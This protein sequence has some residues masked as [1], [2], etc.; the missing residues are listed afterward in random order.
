ML[1]QQAR[2]ALLLVACVTCADAAASTLK[3]SSC[4]AFWPFVGVGADSQ[5]TGFDVQFWGLVYAEMKSVAQSASDATALAMLG[6]KAPDIQVTTKD[7]VLKGVQ[8]GSVDVGLCGFQIDPAQHASLDYSSPVVFSGYKAIVAADEPELTGIEVLKGAMKGFNESAVFSILMLLILS[9]VNAHL[10]WLLE[11][12]DNVQ[13]SKEY[14]WGVFDSWWLSVVTALTV[15]YGDKVPVT[16]FGRLIIVVWMFVGTYCVGMFGAAVTSDFLSV[17]DSGGTGP[18]LS[19]KSIADLDRA[20]TVGTADA[21]ARQYVA[22]A[23]PGIKVTQFSDTGTLLAALAEGMIQVAV[24]EQWHARWLIENDDRFKARNLIPVGDVFASKAHA[25]AISRPVQAVGARGANPIL[26]TLNQAVT[27]LVFGS[28]R[29]RFESVYNSWMLQY[30]PRITTS[31]RDALYKALYKWNII[32]GLGLLGFIIVWGACVFIHYRKEIREAR[33]RDSLLIAMGLHHKFTQQELRDAAHKFFEEIDTDHSGTVDAD[34]LITRLE[35]MGIICATCACV[36]ANVGMCTR[37]YSRA[38]S[39]CMM[40]ASSK[41]PVERRHA[42][43]RS[44]LTFFGQRRHDGDRDGS[45][46]HFRGQQW[47]RVDSERKHTGHENGWLLSPQG[48]RPQSRSKA[49]SNRHAQAH[50]GRE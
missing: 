45:R 34:E 22:D 3:V 24:D 48:Q 6:D 38:K 47:H 10:V 29:A 21:F 39:I 50:S 42:N 26:H 12:H 2:A 9:V 8:D 30:E 49:V 17:T 33:I 18:L 32:Y 1:R 14:G 43:N 27:N 25:L 44:H 20:V 7:A 36:F 5:L 11:R 35:S 4:D 41:R 16:F 46:G 40:K 37:G 19:M 28:G 31:Y 15:G 23:V 13:V